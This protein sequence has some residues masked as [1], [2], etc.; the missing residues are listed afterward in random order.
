MESSKTFNTHSYQGRFK[1]SQHVALISALLC[2][3]TWLKLSSSYSILLLG[4][5]IG[6]R[7][8]HL[9]KVSPHGASL[10][11]SS[12]ALRLFGTDLMLKLVVVLLIFAGKVHDKPMVV[13]AYEGFVRV[14][15]WMVTGR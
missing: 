14:R 7:E 1:F 10:R 6:A 12:H 13:V 8:D 2:Y 5:L 3:L 9:V 15:Y 11:Q 4:I